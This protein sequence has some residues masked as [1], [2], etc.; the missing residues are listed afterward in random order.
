M[1]LKAGNVRLNDFE[2]TASKELD[3]LRMRTSQQAQE[4]DM[5]RSQI[6]VQEEAIL[7]A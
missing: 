3:E 2:V 1:E 5:M 4:I 6:R 7:Q